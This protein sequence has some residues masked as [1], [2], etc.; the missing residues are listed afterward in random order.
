MTV[1]ELLAGEIFEKET[2]NAILACNDWLRLGPGRT[3]PKLIDSYQIKSDTIKR[4]EAPSTSLKTLQTWSCRFN[5][6]E[7]ATEFDAVYEARMN[8]EREAELNYGLALDY[9]RIRALKRLGDLLTDQ[10]YERDPDGN[11]INLWVADVKQIGSGRD[12]EQV[13]IERFNSALITQLRGVLDDLAK[14]VGGRVQKVS[15]VGKDGVIPVDITWRAI[16]EAAQQE[17]ASDDD[18]R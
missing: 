7:R 4:F 12:A 2:N 11:L 14:E 10:L 9:E 3:I 16:V 8:A 5:W 1:I 17:Q 15:G 18:N 13:D 6:A